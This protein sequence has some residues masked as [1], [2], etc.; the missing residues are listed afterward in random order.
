MTD[1]L[2]DRETRLRTRIDKLSAELDQERKLFALLTGGPRDRRVFRPCAWCGT[3]C[4]GRACTLH[5]DV[6]R[7]Y[8]EMTR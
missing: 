4:Y 8:Q 3:Y 1:L 7:T 6:E 5:I 2:V